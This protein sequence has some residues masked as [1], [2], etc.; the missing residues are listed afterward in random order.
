MIVLGWLPASQEPFH[1]M[2]FD[3][4]AIFEW[5]DWYN[6]LTSCVEWDFVDHSWNLEQNRWNSWQWYMTRGV[7]E[8]GSPM[9]WSMDWDV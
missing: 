8:W 1:M 4:P 9:P 2:A 3:L 5:E 6:P 7:L